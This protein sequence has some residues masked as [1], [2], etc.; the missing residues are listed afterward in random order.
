VTAIRILRDVEVPLRDGTRTVAEV[1]VPDDDR[2]H[3]AILVRTPYLKEIAAP[4]AVVDA[5]VATRRGYALVLQDVRGRGASE[6]VFEP[7]VDEEADGADSVAWVAAQPWCD[8]DVVMAG[9]SYFGATQWLA[10]AGA[11]PALRAIAPA[12]SSD[13]YGEGWSY[14]AGIAEHGFLTSW[15]AAELAPMAD[16]MLDDPSRAWE[17]VPAVEAIAPYLGDW[18]SHPPESPFWRRRSVA[19]R[20]ADVRAAAL[21]VAGW[22]DIFLAASLR[23]FA[24]SRDARDRLVVGPWGHS[25]E[26]SHLVG[27][28]NVGIAG[29]GA[30]TFSGWLMDFYDAVL[31][32]R[33]PDLPRVRAYVLGARRW[34]DLDSW[35]P[36]GTQPLI[37]PLEPGAFTVDPATPVPALG[38]RALLVHVPGWGYGIADQRPLLSRDDVHVAARVALE[39]DTLLAGPITARLATTADGND[40]RLW[41][42]TLCVEQ[43][44][45]ALHNLAEGVAAGPAAAECVA[46]D[47]GDTCAWLPAGSTLVLLVAGSSFP[48]WPKPAAAGEQRLRPGSVLHLTTAP[49]ALRQYR[50]EGG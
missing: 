23:S 22:Y 21:V 32:D 17:D 49:A 4:T 47:L 42:A 45:G 44:D 5:R 9:I 1:W 28:A 15:S 24:R 40:E 13:E 35:P 14:R 31:A 43:P 7:F 12:M 38:G 34:L 33:E 8:G 11:P 50:P 48:R 20:R 2:P 36:P 27:G 3:P 30:G 18:L 6:G 25:H 41:A 39:R 37:A 19:H 10:A 46:V 26:L 29:L 16:R